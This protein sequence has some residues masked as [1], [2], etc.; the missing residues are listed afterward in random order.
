MTA[1]HKGGL[2]VILG[3]GFM[4]TLPLLLFST[5]D[6]KQRLTQ[7]TT[8]MR[9]LEQHVGLLD[10]APHE[11]ST[12]KSLLNK[13]VKP[14]SN[15]PERDAWVKQVAPNIMQYEKNEKN[16]KVI[17]RWVWVYAQ[18]HEL[19]PNLILALITI[20]SQFDPFA[21][22]SVGA[23]GLMQI[24]PFWKKEL[25]NESDNLFDV[26][27]NIRYGCTILKHYFKRYKTAKKALAAYTGS[28]GKSKYPHKIFTVL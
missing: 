27:T 16:A 7:S 6:E 24:M 4:I 11:R 25:G 20:E 14:L 26:A 21:I 1:K 9:I 19:D 22:S 13:E 5:P 12:L 23:Q 8:T 2:V 3:L 17:A 18:R 10:I 28:K 15:Q